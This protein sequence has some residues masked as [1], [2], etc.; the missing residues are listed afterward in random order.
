[1]T[2]QSKLSPKSNTK[3]ST[4]KRSVVVNGVRKPTRKSTPSQKIFDWVHT[5]VSL[6]V[7]IVVFGGIGTYFLIRSF[8]ATPT[9]PSTSFNITTWNTTFDNPTNIGTSLLDLGRNSDIIGLQEMH[10]PAQRKNIKTRLLCSTCKYTGYVKDYT[11]NGSSPASLP[12]LWN[13]AKFAYVSKGYYTMSSKVTGINDLTGTNMSI[14]AKYITWV[15]LR[16][17]ATTRSFYVLNLHTVAGVEWSSFYHA[18]PVPSGYPMTPNIKRLEVY[19]KG[20]DV[21]VSKVQTLAKTGRP[22]IIIGDF[23]V[24]YRFDSIVKDPMFPYARLSPLKVTSSYET[25]KQV[26]ADPTLATH[27]TD[28]RLIDYVFAVQNSRLTV[29]NEYIDTLTYG[30]DHHP[31]TNTMTIYNADP[32]TVPAPALIPIGVSAQE[33]TKTVTTDIVTTETQ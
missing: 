25:L 11:Y 31:V 21:L 20:M 1:M 26:T 17:K 14:S 7:F 13:K 27:G 16:D 19:K 24:D 22:I 5:H 4:T 32:A 2:K 8:A 12:I 15:Q 3:N 9:A 10:T 28:S 23:N 30:S 33:A 18:A 29:D 6:V